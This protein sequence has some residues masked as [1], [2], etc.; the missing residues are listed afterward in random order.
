ML[1]GAGTINVILL[2]SGE[3][4]PRAFVKQSS[5]SCQFIVSQLGCGRQTHGLAPFIFF[6]D[7]LGSVLLLCCLV[8]VIFLVLMKLAS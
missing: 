2:R 3:R 5:L 7:R 8:S 1:S 4:K 6:S